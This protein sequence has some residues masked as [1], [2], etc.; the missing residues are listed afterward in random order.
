MNLS[1]GN[2]T[3]K[4]N[5]FNMCRQLNEENENED[6]IDEQKELFE[7]CIEENIQQGD[8]SELSNVCLVNSIES[9]K[10]LEL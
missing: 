8:F 7:S 3:M 4:L 9:N 1:F 6:D 2:M 10:Q 5:V